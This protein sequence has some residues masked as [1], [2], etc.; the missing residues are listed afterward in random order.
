MRDRTAGPETGP[1]SPAP[2]RLAADV[3][4]SRCAS[5]WSV[6][7]WTAAALAARSSLS[8][9]RPEQSTVTTPARRHANASMSSASVLVLTLPLTVTRPS[10]TLMSSSSGEIQSF[11][12][13]RHSQLVQDLGIRAGKRRTRSARLTIPTSLPSLRTGR[14]FT[15]CSTMSL[16][17]SQTERSTSIVTG[18]VVIASA[19]VVAERRRSSI[20]SETKRLPENP[21]AF[22]PACRLDDEVGFRDDPEHEPLAVD[23]GYARDAAFHHEPGDL[24]QR[25]ALA[26][27]CHVRVMTSLTL[28]SASSAS[29]FYASIP[30]CSMAQP[31]PAS[32]DS[33]NPR[34]GEL[35]RSSCP[36]VARRDVITIRN[37]PHHDQRTHRCLSYV[38]RRG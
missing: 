24:L 34:R 6:S 14:R 20:A 33:L 2:A 29:A 37:S 35:L 36:H 30:R 26:H 12:G 16:A 23:D 9:T 8:Q 4:R 5:R 18:G 10:T 28:I 22:R 19:A 13:G 25:R 11:L 21:G 17:A 3:R 1:L 31:A 15:R 38:Q 7:Y 27:R 32:E